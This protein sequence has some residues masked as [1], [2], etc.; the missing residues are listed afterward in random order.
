MGQ[1]TNGALKLKT[2][3]LLRF[4]LYFQER[5][6]IGLVSFHPTFISPQIYFTTR[7]FHPT[8]ISL[9]IHFTQVHFTPHL[10][11]QMRLR[12]MTIAIQ[13]QS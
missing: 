9:Q 13:F 4:T 3:I 10:N 12:L 1:I 11:Y 7:S 8:F 5:R 6:I 2:P